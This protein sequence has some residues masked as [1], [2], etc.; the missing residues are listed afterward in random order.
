MMQFVYIT[1]LTK[2]QTEKLFTEWQCES[3]LPKKGEC[4]F[5]VPPGLYSYRI[6]PTKI[7]GGKLG[8]MVERGEFKH[9]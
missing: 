6:T 3:P 9:S 7:N 8:Y 2:K 1:S 4:V 5:Y